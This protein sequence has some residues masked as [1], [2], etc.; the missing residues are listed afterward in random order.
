MKQRYADCRCDLSLGP[1]QAQRVGLGSA[2]AGQDFFGLAFQIIAA[3]WSVA[4]T[5]WAGLRMQRAQGSSDVGSP[6]SPN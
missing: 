3:V 4:Q 2:A 6:L 1:R 5:H